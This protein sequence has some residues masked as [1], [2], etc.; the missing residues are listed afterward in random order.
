MRNWSYAG[1]K[2][3]S[4]EGLAQECRLRELGFK[5]G[6]CQLNDQEE[7]EIDTHICTFIAWE[8][9]HIRIVVM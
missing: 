5:V 3:I 6:I 9:S 1:K 4:K 7:K 2:F 8:M